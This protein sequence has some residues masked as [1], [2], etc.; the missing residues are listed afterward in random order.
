MF[1]QLLAPLWC[2]VRCAKRNFS[3]NIVQEVCPALQVIVET[4]S[5]DQPTLRIEKA[6]NSQLS[7]CPIPI[8]DDFQTLLANSESVFSTAQEKKQRLTKLLRSCGRKQ[9]KHEFRVGQ[10]LSLML[11][12]RPLLI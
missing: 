8:R 6:M 9:T 12:K 10:G 3:C 5:R 1:I 2:V 4:W 7:I 11:P